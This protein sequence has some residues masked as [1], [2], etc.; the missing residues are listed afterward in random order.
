MDPLGELLVAILL[1]VIRQCIP[2]G[3]SEQCLLV[4]SVLH[5]RVSFLALPLRLKN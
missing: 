5:C 4:E 2:N 3:P 1:Y